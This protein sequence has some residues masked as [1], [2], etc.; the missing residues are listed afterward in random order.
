MNK[1]EIK[2]ILLTPEDVMDISEYFDEIVDVLREVKDDDEKMEYT[3]DM[4][5]ISGKIRNILQLSDNKI[6][7]C[8]LCSPMECND[9]SIKF[10]KEYYSYI[11]ME[12]FEY[13]DEHGL[14]YYKI[15]D[16]IIGISSN[17]TINS[18]FDGVNMDIKT[19]IDNYVLDNYRDLDLELLNICSNLTIEIES[20]DNIIHNTVLKLLQTNNIKMARKINKK[21]RIIMD[22]DETIDENQ[23]K[24][25]NEIENYINYVRFI[26]NNL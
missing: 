1:K 20:E 21:R 13:C 4:L 14:E 5:S 23:D 22:I 26:N 2:E 25:M 19:K 8:Y 18:D 3:L 24:L 17:G 12:L 6:E 16:I 15:V 11:N 10:W 9:R 7:H